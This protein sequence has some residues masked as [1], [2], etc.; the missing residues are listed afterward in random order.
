MLLWVSEVDGRS[1]HLILA[2]EVEKEKRL[3]I[4]LGIQGICGGFL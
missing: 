4:G 3:S 2:G 1:G